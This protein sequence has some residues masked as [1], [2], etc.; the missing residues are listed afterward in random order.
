MLSSHTFAFCIDFSF[1]VPCL[2]SRN[3]HVRFDDFRLFWMMEDLRKLRSLIMLNLCLFSKQLLRTKWSNLTM[4]CSLP[5]LQEA[6]N[7]SH[8]I[9]QVLDMFLIWIVRTYWNH[10]L[11]HQIVEFVGFFI[12]FTWEVC[13]GHM[14]SSLQDPVPN[15]ACIWSLEWEGFSLNWGGRE[16]LRTCIHCYFFFVS[17]NEKNWILP[18]LARK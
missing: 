8:L 2:L 3:L 4:V 10:H 16:W 6:F 13:I 11:K 12:L 9:F 17:Q 15:K 14:R 7:N 18:K 5:F 1:L